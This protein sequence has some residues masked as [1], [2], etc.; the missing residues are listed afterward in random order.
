MSG[1]KNE[2]PPEPTRE[3]LVEYVSQHGPTFLDRFSGLERIT[4]GRD[5]KGPVVW[6]TMKEH[7]EGEPRKWLW[8]LP[9]KKGSQVRFKFRWLERS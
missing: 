4:V 3:E 1:K 5:S 6:L 8:P 2:G 7:S 9:K